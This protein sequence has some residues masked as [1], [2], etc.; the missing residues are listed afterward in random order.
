MPF[1]KGKEPIRRT[2]EYLTSGKLA[3]KDR[4]KILSI[5]Y[6]TFGDHHKGARYINSRN[7]I[8]TCSFY[9]M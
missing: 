9:N 5:N 2:I 3:L 8:I 6:N 1:M 4:I 7:G